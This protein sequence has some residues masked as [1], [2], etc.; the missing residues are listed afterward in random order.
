MSFD[1]KQEPS[2]IAEVVHHSLAHSKTLRTF[3]AQLVRRSLVLASVWLHSVVLA[4]PSALSRIC[5][6]PLHSMESRVVEP[7]RRLA[8]YSAFWGATNF[9]RCRPTTIFSC[10]RHQAVFRGYSYFRKYSEL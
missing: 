2:S 5:L 7:A 10:A 1:F 9:Y 8:E 4:R 3:L 6:L